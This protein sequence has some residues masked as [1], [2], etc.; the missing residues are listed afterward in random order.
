MESNSM[1]TLTVTDLDRS[2]AS[3]DRLLRIDAPT[4]LPPQKAKSPSRRKVRAEPDEGKKL[5]DEIRK[6]IEE[7]GLF[8]YDTDNPF[9]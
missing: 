7:T 9:K 2:S 8:D 3:N 4:P 1:P 5:L 6:E